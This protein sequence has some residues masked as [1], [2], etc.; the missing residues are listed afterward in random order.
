MPYNGTIPQPADQISTSQGEM[1]INF[2]DIQTLIQVN[3]VGFNVANQ[4]KHKYVTFP[5]QAAA[6]ATLANEVN[7]F[8]QQSVYSLQP[9]LA[10]KR[11]A[12][13]AQEITTSLNNQT[14]WCFTSSGMLLKWGQ[15]T[16]LAVDY[17]AGTAFDFPVAETIPVYGT[18]FMMYITPIAAGA[19]DAN[20]CA[21]LRAL[22]V[23]NF[24]VRGSQRTELVGADTVFNYLA[25][26]I[27]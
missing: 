21:T 20:T 17:P 14:G 6:P 9:E 2:A 16:A 15:L 8:A 1:L 3:H 11:N 24:T 10:F 13:N 22:N 19:A 18:V 23:A 27:L 5:N 4:G 25:I 7:L 12:G 26:G